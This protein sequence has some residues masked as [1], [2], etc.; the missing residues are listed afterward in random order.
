MRSIGYDAL[1]EFRRRVAEVMARFPVVKKYRSGGHAGN[2]ASKGNVWVL[3]EQ[4]DGLLPGTTHAER[5]RSYK[6]LE[7]DILGSLGPLVAT[8]GTLKV[9]GM[10]FPRGVV[11]EPEVTAL[12][13]AVAE[14]M[15]I[16]EDDQSVKSLSAAV[17]EEAVMKEE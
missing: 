13:G 11:Y 17:A 7:G 16:R 4:F 12:A 8:F 2:K 5:Y 9:P 10:R 3:I 1:E 15:G 6:K 14:A